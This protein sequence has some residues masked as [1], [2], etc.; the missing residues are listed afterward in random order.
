MPLYQPSNI[1]PSL[2]GAF[3]SGV[4]ISN[5]PSNDNYTTISWQVNGT[6]PMTAFEITIRRIDRPTTRWWS[7][8]KLTTNCPFYPSDGNGNQQ[9]F[10]FTTLYKYLHDPADGGYS[11][12]TPGVTAGQ[13]YLMYITQ[14]WQ[15]PDSNWVLT[16]QSIT[17][18]S[19][20]KFY[21]R[22]KGTVTITGLNN[23]DSLTGRTQSF[24]ATYGGGSSIDSVISAR[25]TLCKSSGDLILDT[26]WLSTQ[27]LSFSYNGFAPGSSY[28]IQCSIETE[29]GVVVESD[30][31]SF[32]IATA[33]V[34]WYGSATACA[35]SKINGVLVRWNPAYYIPVSVRIIPPTIKQTIDND[36]LLVGNQSIT[37]NHVNS[38]QMSFSFPIY[39]IWEGYIT[40]L[41][42]TAF[43]LGFA[44]GSSYSLTINESDSFFGGRTPKVGDKVVVQI[45]IENDYKGSFSIYLYGNE[46]DGKYKTAEGE[47][48]LTISDA[49]NG[50]LASLFLDEDDS[51]TAVYPLQNSVWSDMASKGWKIASY[52]MGPLNPTG[53]ITSV[54]LLAP[55]DNYYFWLTN[56]SPTPRS[57]LPSWD[58]IGTVFLLAPWNNIPNDGAG[59]VETRTQYNGA[60]VYRSIY[61][62]TL[63]EYVGSATDE[64][65]G[66]IDVGAKSQTEYEYSVFVKGINNYQPKTV[67]ITPCFWN[68]VLYACTNNS[69]GSYTPTEIFQFRYNVESGAISNNNTPTILQNFTRYPTVLLPSANYRSGVLT[70]YIGSTSEGQYVDTL[71]QRDALFALSS[72]PN[73][74]LYL[75][76][77]KGDFIRVMISAPISSVT[78]DKTREQAQQISVPW[79]EV[80]DANNDRVILT[81]ADDLYQEPNS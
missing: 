37:W 72:S 55:Q 32:S 76:N 71:A 8:G 10:S 35:L 38:Y 47:G 43:R 48:I 34:A 66:I 63:Y 33:T 59:N 21:T 39:G 60:D 1:S 26:G 16:E 45:K 61:G 11:G 54:T 19:P 24:T 36:L 78:A 56:G 22:N 13:T 28:S 51:L 64:G 73:T 50:T 23:G 30:V 3:G 74:I 58:D 31:V 5:Y 44:N 25:W 6:T 65:H 79:V 52:S 70:G 18:T 27:V 9:L 17:T 53:N 49:G 57:G 14:Y 12:S 29:N 2:L 67:S 62:D 41:P 75:K 80:A 77:R 4:V 69:D 40:Q 15:E 81:E 68:W 42:M 7:S 20:V 46:G